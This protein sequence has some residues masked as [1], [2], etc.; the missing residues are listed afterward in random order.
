MIRIKQYDHISMAVPALDPQIELL[1]KLFGFRFLSKFESDEGYFGANLQIPGSSGLDWEILAPRAEQ[2][3]LHRFL[4][5]PS[6]PGLH[7]MALQIESAV[8][9]ADDIRAQGMEPWGFRP[10]A[11]GAHEGGDGVVYLHPRSGGR[12]FLW[13]MYAGAPW[14]ESEPFEDERTDTLGIVAVNHLAHAA[15]SAREMADWYASVFGCTPVYE[16]PGDGLRSGFRT[17]V[18]ET[19]TKQLRF[20]MIEPAGEDSFIA[21]FLDQR[22][23][24][25]H[26]I[27]FQVRDFDQA[28]AACERHQ[29]PTF[30]VQSGTREGAGWSEAFIHPRHTGGMLVQFFWEERPGIW[31]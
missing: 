14:H 7:H 4:D 29:V 23:E 19:Q 11:E 25:M 10:H 26:H 5:G 22:G 13:Q 16:T 21:R 1:E 3:Y 28:M 31:V 18:L 24:G 27:N 2:S 8:A 15:R 17:I 6:G 12:G 20:E 9:A 30:G